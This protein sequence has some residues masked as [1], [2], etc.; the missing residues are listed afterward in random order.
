MKLDLQKVGSI[1]FTGNEIDITDPCY[2]K[3]VLC[4]EKRKIQ[5]GHYNCYTGTINFDGD[6]RICALIILSESVDP[7]EMPINARRDGQIGV[8]A[9]VAGFFENKPDYNDA[10]WTEICSYLYPKT[11]MQGGTG[12]SSWIVDKGSP[13]KCRGFFSYSGFGDGVYDFYRLTR[14]RKFVGYKLVF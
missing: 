5:L 10:E 1:E 11:D 6:K 14:N 4:R 2:D 9:G 13:F 3:N 7:D 12:C 8:D